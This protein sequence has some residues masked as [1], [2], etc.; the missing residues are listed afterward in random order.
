MSFVWPRLLWLLL[1]LP[2]LVLLYVSILRQ[3][4]ATMLRHAGL[5][6]VQ[7]ALSRNRGW[8]RHLPPLLFLLGLAAMMVAMARPVAVLTLPQEERTIILAM[9]ISGS[10]RAADVGP[11]RLAAAQAAAHSFVAAVPK[12]TR[13][14]VV[15]FAATAALVQ[16]PTRNHEEID[17]AIDR[18]QLQR[19][20]AVGS[21][22]LVALAAIFPEA[23]IDIQALTGEG[24]APPLRPGSTPPP[25]KP[26]K[27]PPVAPGSYPDAAIVLLSDGQR[28]AGPAVEE[29][30]QFVADRGVRVYTV[31]IGTPEG[32]VVGYE[33]WSMRVRLDEATL[34]GVADAT[35]G[36]YFHATSASELEQIYRNLGSRLVMKTQQTEVSALFSAL[37]VLLALLAAFLSL[38]W[39]KRVL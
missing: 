14:G 27:P 11:N 31:G 16:P 6:L 10:M 2:L 4:H 20:T 32:E 23:G 25:P 30:A 35:R 36:D 8:R 3:Q 18:F 19:G 15:A 9:D 24:E 1:L 34:K 37:G 39:F 29:A 7:E 38:Y 21:G 28:T 26:P 17:A 33:G 12:S 13:V 5:A 22:L